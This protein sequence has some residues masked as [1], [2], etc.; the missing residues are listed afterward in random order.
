VSKNTPNTKLKTY[1]EQTYGKK[2]AD[3][4]VLEYKDRLAKFF[5]LL[6]QIDQ[7]NKRKSNEIK[8]I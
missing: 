2:L 3:E 1:L 7:R 6:I 5:D 8:T 4:K